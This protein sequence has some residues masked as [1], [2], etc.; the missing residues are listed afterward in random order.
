MDPELTKRVA[1]AVKAGMEARS[2]FYAAIDEPDEQQLGPPTSPAL[3]EKLE[4]KVGLALPP[5][6]KAFLTLYDG[7]RMVD[8]V[9]D[10]M[11][12]EDMLSGPRADDI[13]KWQQDALK[14]GDEVCGKGLVI[15]YSDISQSRIILH[16][17]RRNDDG[18]WR[19]YETYKDEETEYDSFI[20]WLEY[21][22][23]HYLKMAANPT[24]DDEEA[25]PPDDDEDAPP[26]D[27]DEE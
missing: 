21:C 19:L 7:W 16:P 14:W 25:P 12:V 3:I 11:P 1:A 4:Q 23:D 15:G 22:V 18:E 13:R 17:L 20:A 8:A 2:K 9:T 26:P 27:D 24:A 5:S 10:L 6:Y